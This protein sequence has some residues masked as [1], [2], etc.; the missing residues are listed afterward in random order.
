MVLFSEK[1]PASAAAEAAALGTIAEGGAKGGAKL[2]NNNDTPEQRAVMEAA[3]SSSV[4]HPN[5]VCTCVISGFSRFR[6]IA[7]FR[8]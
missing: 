7:V 3:V 5:V 8:V 4:V 1:L 2:P 6:R